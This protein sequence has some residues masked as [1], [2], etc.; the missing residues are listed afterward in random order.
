MIIIKV[1]CS[2]APSSNCKEVYERINYAKECSF[3]GKNNK[4]YIT[5][6]DNYTHAI[7]INTPMPELKIPKENVVGLAFEPIYFLNLTAEFIDYAKKHVGKYF[8]GD[9]FNLP[10]PFMEHFGYMWHS[11][12]PKEINIKNKIMSI[13]VSEKKFAPGHKYRHELVEKI[14][15]LK[16]P[17]DI[18]GRGS[19][20]YIY[21]DRIMGQFN[22]AE[23]YEN[24]YFSICIEN[25]ISNHYFSEKIA[26]PLMYNCM[27]VYY[28]CRNITNYV[29]NV[30][31]LSG[32]VEKDIQLIKNIIENTEFY[33]KKTFT[34]KNKKAVNLIENLPNI[35]N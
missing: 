26:T 18:Y 5:N 21:K 9:K 32:D 3:Y 11:R 13:I 24:Y 12:P 31:I 27:P 28:G 1:F 7:L 17:V 34:E 14:I 23:P 35:F 19:N 16:L 4:Y 22:D 6:D 33:Y 30:N 20:N 29:E 2:F 10:E 8:I 15:K 25:V